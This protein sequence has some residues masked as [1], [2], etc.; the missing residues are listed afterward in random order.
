MHKSLPSLPSQVHY[1]GLYSGNKL[2]LSEATELG[3]RGGGLL[4]HYSNSTAGCTILREVPQTLQGNSWSLTLLAIHYCPS[5][6][7]RHRLP[8]LLSL[9]VGPHAVGATSCALALV[10][11]MPGSPASAVFSLPW[12]SGAGSP[13]LSPAPSGLPSTQRCQ[14]TRVVS[15]FCIP[16]PAAL[17]LERR[18]RFL[19]SFRGSAP[20]TP[21]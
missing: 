21:R 6:E 10:F 15:H 17:N 7:F 4:L 20:K 19:P 8:F 13:A 12:A 16:V 9:C 1:F 18:P 11:A 5:Q 3:G 2:L 14:N